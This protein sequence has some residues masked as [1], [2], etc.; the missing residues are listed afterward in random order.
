MESRFCW[1]ASAEGFVGGFVVGAEAVEAGVEEFAEFGDVG[2][3]LG[4]E[5]GEVGSGGFPGAAGFGGVVGAQLG[6]LASEVVVERL[7][8]SVET[9]ELP[10]EGVG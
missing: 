8:A 9:G 2:G 4:A 3:D 10:G 6:E 7:R 1:T 5:G